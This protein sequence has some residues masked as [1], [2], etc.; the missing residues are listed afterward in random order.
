MTSSGA[1]SQKRAFL[2]PLAVA[3]ARSCERVVNV[4]A[5]DTRTVGVVAGRY[6][7]RCPAPIAVTAVPHVSVALAYSPRTQ[8]LACV[9]GSGDSPG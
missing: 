8:T 7:G 5:V 2:R 9:L 1:V 4:V 6:L 3:S